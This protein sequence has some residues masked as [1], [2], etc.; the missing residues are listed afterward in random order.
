MKLMSEVKKWNKKMICIGLVAALVSGIAGCGSKNS[1]STAETI[2]ETQV[3]AE[4]TE[5]KEEIEVMEEEHNTDVV[6][7][8][9]QNKNSIVDQLEAMAQEYTELTGVKVEIMGAAGDNYQDTLVGKLTSGQGPTIFSVSEGAQLEKLNSYLYD[10]SDQ[11]Y[12]DQIADGMALEVD[13]K[14][15]GIPYAVEGYGLVYNESLMNGKTISNLDEFTAVAEEFRGQ[16]I[17]FMELS[18]KAFFL[19]GHILNVPFALQDDYKDYLEKLNAGEVKMAETPEF[20]EWAKFMEVIRD[21]SENPMSITYDDQAANLATGKTV[22]IHQ[23]NWVWLMFNDYG[24]DFDMSI[25]PLPVMGNDKICSGIPNAWVINNQKSQEEI[26]EALK[27]FEW[28]FTTERGHYY[29]TEEFG[30]IPAMK[31][32]DAGELDPLASSVHEYVM[33]GKTLPWTYNYWP[34]GMVNN[35]IMAVGQKFFSDS[36]MTGEQ[37]LEALDQ[38]WSEGVN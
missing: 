23:G 1:N 8:I 20:Q 38:A 6:I 9:F 11:S 32:I 33:N 28:M 27:F 13:G 10:L 14:V 35:Q 3:S 12:V 2:P 22:S 26:D 16:G 19:I 30:F 36:S 25:A 29:I 5:A 15:L 34:D 21:T 4:E 17:D 24:I 18:D 37:L 7:S 31:N